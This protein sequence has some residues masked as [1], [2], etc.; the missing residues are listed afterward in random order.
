ML[1]DPAKYGDA[2]GATPDRLRTAAWLQYLI[3]RLDA[4]ACAAEAG[5]AGDTTV[6]SAIRPLKWCS[7]SSA[8]TGAA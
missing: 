7:R 3:E 6:I 8:K 1:T 5:D 2:R 4:D